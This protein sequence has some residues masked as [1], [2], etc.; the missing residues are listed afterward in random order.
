MLNEIKTWDGRTMRWGDRVRFTDSPMGI[1]ISRTLRGWTGTI[2]SLVSAN[3]VYVVW[4]EAE[5][6]VLTSG[7]FTS[8]L[9]LVG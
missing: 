6:T 9:M 4:E 7:E 3:I 8:N 2:V 1:P 5:R